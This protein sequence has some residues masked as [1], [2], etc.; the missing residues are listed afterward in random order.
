MILIK[1]NVRPRSLWIAVAAANQAQLEGRTVVITSGN[2]SGHMRAS[3]HYSDDAL[4]FRSK[5]FGS[6]AAK[7]AF[8][9][10]VLKR[11]GASYEGLLEDLGGPNEHFHVEYDPK[12]AGLQAARAVPPSSPSRG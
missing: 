10:A 6:T 7:R 11:L 2:D 12:P 3:R 5:D 9:A 8:L 4:D 1:S